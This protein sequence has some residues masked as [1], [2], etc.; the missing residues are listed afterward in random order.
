MKRFEY[1]SSVIL[2]DDLSSVLNAMGDVGW[3][4]SYLERWA[5]LDSRKCFILLE[6]ETIAP[7]SD[8]TESKQNLK[9][10]E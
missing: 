4:V 5:N 3:R 6:R 7:A 2:E 1:K 10:S 9:P 8:D